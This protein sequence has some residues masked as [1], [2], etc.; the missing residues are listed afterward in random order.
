MILIK[1]Y[2]A[3]RRQHYIVSTFDKQ[4]GDLMEANPRGL[5]FNL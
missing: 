1:N 4:F 2:S 3:R 5:Q